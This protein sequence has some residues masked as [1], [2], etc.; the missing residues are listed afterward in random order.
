MAIETLETFGFKV[1]RFQVG[2]GVLPEVRSTV[3]GSLKGVK[4]DE[5]REIIAKSENKKILVAMLNALL[6]AKEM[7]ER[8]RLVGFNQVALDL[9]LGLPP[10]IS[11]ELKPD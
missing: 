4:E 1:T 11:F 8:A 3:R 7:Q 9:K 6:A 5:I 10:S 2:M